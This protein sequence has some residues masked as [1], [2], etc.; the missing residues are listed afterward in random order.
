[1]PANLSPEYME[2]E[3]RLRTLKS[4]EERLECLRYM[5][6]VIPKHK[7]TDKMQANL[8]KRISKIRDKLE[9]QAKNKKKGPVHKIT[10]EGA[11][12]VALA[13]PPNVG[14]SALLSA[15]SGVETR[16]AQ[17]PFTTLEPQPGM[18]PYENIQIQLVDFPPV[19]REHTEAWVYDLIKSCDAFL[20]VVDLGQGDPLQEFEETLNLLKDHNLLPVWG[21]M[22]GEQ[23]P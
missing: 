7:G 10:H 11:G 12:T 5:L 8:K 18:M 15:L 23:R 9:Q 14:K 1:M 2:A 16:V 13:G 22:P 17:Y 20:L 4:D 19:C 21:E 3:K 6:S